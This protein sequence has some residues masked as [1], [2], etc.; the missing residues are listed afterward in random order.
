MSLSVDA[1][2]RED[3]PGEALNR[4][5]IP[6]LLARRAQS[7]PHSCFLRFQG[8]ELTFAEVHRWSDV[9]ADRFDAL[10]IRAGQLVPV[11]MPN[12]P[13]FVA[14]WFALCKLGAVTTM[15]NTAMRGPALAHALDLSGSEIAIVDASLLDAV[16]SI[17]DQL[18]TINRLV[19][20]GAAAATPADDRFEVLMFPA[21][22][23]DG[24]T[25]VSPRRTADAHDPAMVMFT[26]GTT[27][28][29]KGCVLSHRYAIRQAE[30]MV[31]HLGLRDD[32][33]LYC[34]FPLFHL[35]GAVLTV[36]P[37][38]LL[39]ATAAIGERFSASG[40]WSEVDAL[41]ATVFDFMGATLTMLHKAPPRAS[42]AHNTVRLAWGVPVPEF[43]EDFEERFSLRLVELYGSTDAGLPIYQPLDE[44]RRPGSCGRVIASYEVQLFDD[45]DLAV[46][47][48]HVGEIVVRPN[49]PSIMSQG[50][51]GM[52]EATVTANRN[53]WFHTGDLAR[54]DADGWFYY[55]GRR[56]ESI[57]RRGENISAFEIE[58]VVK[59][60]P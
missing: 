8:T 15:V 5:T 19:V 32:D 40:F 46:A 48:G 10:G 17:E 31:E 39:G 7:H 41:G 56:A 12:I 23:T 6:A 1:R 4:S 45:H 50:Y 3:R 14:T 30:L 35:D 9:L 21:R 2:A 24:T 38:M 20:R 11:L 58:E 22:E 27:G 26:S 52:P 42:D 16:R 34:P 49:E 44:P 60:H 57:R 37:A 43:A 53:Q 25:A 59:L 51:F 55:V 54:Q 13:E 28:R 47:P 29:S 33:V 36:M 18:A